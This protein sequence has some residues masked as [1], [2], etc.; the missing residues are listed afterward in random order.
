MVLRVLQQFCQQV[1]DFDYIDKMKLKKK[2][3]S[4]WDH[5]NQQLVA[6]FAKVQQARDKLT[7][8]G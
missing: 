7:R 5:G 1:G 3:D 4:Q 2:C 8:S 6:Y